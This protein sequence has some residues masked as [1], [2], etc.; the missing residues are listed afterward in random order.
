MAESEPKPVEDSGVSDVTTLKRSC[1]G[2]VG[3]LARYYKELEALLTDPMNYELASK[4]YA[5][6]NK[7]FESYV[8]RYNEYASK[9]EEKE[10]DVASEQFEVNRVNKVEFDKR[11]TEWFQEVQKV[12]DKDDRPTRCDTEVESV[13]SY[14]SKGSALSDTSSIRLKE[15]K[16]KKAL[17]DLKRQQF[18]KMQKLREQQFQLEQ[19]LARAEVE[20]DIA[21]AEAELHIWQEEIRTEDGRGEEPK[22]TEDT[23]KVGD[24]PREVKGPCVTLNPNAPEFI[25]NVETGYDSMGKGNLSNESN[26]S[27]FMQAINL[28]VHMPKPE[29]EVFTGNPVEYW[30]FINNFEASIASKVSDDRVKLTYLLQFCENEVKD[31][32]S[33]CVLMEPTEGYQ[34]ARDILAKQYGQPHVVAHALIKQVL[35]RAQLKPNDAKELSDLARSMRKCEITLSQTGYLAD[36]HSSDTLLKVQKLLPMYMQSDWAK[37]AQSNMLRGIVPNF[38]H[39]T[40][41]VEEYVQV[42]N[43]IYGRNMGTQVKE[44]KQLPRGVKYP[45]N[46]GR[47]LTTLTTQSSQRETYVYKVAWKCPCCSQRHSLDACK[48]FQSKSQRDRFKLIRKLRLCDN[49]FKPRHIASDC[50]LQP[51]CQVEGCNRRHHTLLHIYPTERNSESPQTGSGEVD[52]NERTQGVSLSTVKSPRVCLRVLPVKVRGNGREVT[53]LALLDQGS[54]TSLCE[55][56][57]VRE[58]GIVGESAVYEL[59]TVNSPA[60]VTKGVEIA[61]EVVG[62]EGNENIELLNVWSVESLPVTKRSIPTQDQVNKWPHLRDIEFQTMDR[63]KVQLLIGSDTPEAFWVLEERRGKR[64][65]PYAVR[66]PLGW[67]VMGPLAGSC[68]SPRSFLVNHVAHERLEEQVK[69]FWELDHGFGGSADERVCDSINDQR[70]RKIMEDSVVLKDGHY[71]M[72]LPWRHYPPSLPNN[73][74]MVESRLGS[75]RK[76][77]LKDEDLHQ[78]YKAVMEDYLRK[79]YA[80]KV[81]V[82]GDVC[83]RGEIWYLPHH[84]VI[85]PNKPNKLRIVFDCAAQ[86]QGLSLNSQLL[87][88]PDNTN[89]LIGVLTRFREEKIAIAADIEGM[90]NQVRVAPRDL[91]ALRF[92]WWDEGDLTT[93]PQEFQMCVHLF[94]AT[95]SPSCAGFALRRTAD[96]N[97]DSFDEE[98]RQTVYDNFYVDDC[99]RSVRTTEDGRRLIPQLRDMLSLGGFRLTK[100]VSNDREVLS[101]VPPAE[102]A[103]SVVDLDF[104]HLPL[105]RTLGVLWDMESDRFKFKVAVKDVPNTR[106]GILSATSSLYDPLGLVAPFTLEGKVLLQDL[107]AQGLSWDEPVKDE[108][109]RRWQNWLEEL[110]DLESAEISRCIKPPYFDDV[111][112]DVH[113]FGDASERGYAV[114]AYVRTKDSGGKVHCTLLM[115]KARVCPIKKVTVPRL[116]LTAATLA[117]KVGQVL[118]SELSIPLKS[119]TYWTDSTTVLLYVRNEGRRFKT[120]VANRV[121][122]IR[123]ASTVDQ[124]RYVDTHQNPADDGSRGL[125][126]RDLTSTCRW[127]NGPAFLWDAEENWPEIPSGIENLEGRELPDNIQDECK[128]KKQTYLNTTNGVVARLLEKY[129]SWTRLK[130]GVAWILRYKEYLV[131]RY[132]GKQPCKETVLSLQELKEAEL[133][134]IKYVQQ[135]A[136]HEELHLLRQKKVSK[137]WSNNAFNKINPVLHDGVL[138]VGG[139][140]RNAP[141]AYDEMHPI[142][143]PSND[144]VTSLIIIHHHLLVGHSGSGMT[145]SSLRNKF[146]ILKGGAAVRKVIGKCFDCKRRNAPRGSQFMSELP[147]VRVTPDNPPFTFVGVDYFGPLWVKQGRSQVKRWGCVFTC[148]TMRAVHIELADNLDTDSFLNALRRFIS[149]RGTPAKIL[150]DNGSNFKG[151]ER[152]L[153]EAVQSLNNARTENF[154]LNKEIEWQFNPPAA[155]HMGGIWE[156]IIRS[157]RRILKA[158]VKEQLIN[159]EVLTTLLTE[160]EA[161]LNARPLTQIS[162][163]PRDNQPLTPNHLLLLK[164]NPNIAPGEFVKT[165]GYGRRRWRQCQYL[166]NQFW[167]RWIREYLPLLQTRQKW[168]KEKRSLR[169]GD[170]VLMVNESLP[171]GKWSVGRVE[172]VFPDRFGRVRQVE[173]RVGSQYYKRPIVKLCL[174]EEADSE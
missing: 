117:V 130:R 137:L 129:S 32:I 12:P 112:Y 65:E 90:F 16:A 165:D 78:R 142:I 13:R 91:D 5:E 52:K 17:A 73:R 146:W 10:A 102:R 107:C 67:T 58:L 60:T 57:L 68:G 85:N 22:G 161:I 124:W 136:F 51:G 71:Q 25:N 111:S 132:R 34:R 74:T 20:N 53:T 159:Q 108:E 41:F 101:M 157:V 158:L 162:L 143:L 97:Q 133:A 125:H 64:K 33:C 100:W 1:S 151:G 46:G 19:E 28:S 26:L 168:N 40:E 109:L 70:A 156:R 39:I 173:I 140:L 14:R 123:E 84:P 118:Q 81:D 134:V 138:R 96:D 69:R 163:D 105:E 160:V 116:E 127:L 121:A 30:S 6:L 171:R 139:R 87:Q 45:M 55:N 95:S 150:S 126:A 79:G 110:P 155:S 166:A 98:V 88:G 62:L 56:E 131:A 47:R 122:A 3:L 4:K 164:G 29:L 23:G 172:Q 113:I 50:R 154:L 114:S 27:Q 77:L 11:I 128:V 49:C 44:T 119:T 31:S 148:M 21:S 149:R 147:S 63:E 83:K 135:K 75:L 2:Y 170:L 36:L 72:R 86:Y 93:S 37:R 103:S 9:L 89:S 153:R 174:L 144:R 54:D 18:I 38:R 48:D 59:S 8:T 167:R 80:R 61:L 169:V 76:R 120:F 145:W 94:G 15:A 115:G 106:R 35:N 7:I 24:K 152:E 43:S 82:S 66:T 42:A 141:V 92:L 99:L 104:T